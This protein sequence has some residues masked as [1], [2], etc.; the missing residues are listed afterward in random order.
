MIEKGEIA[1]DGK[2]MDLIK[3]SEFLRNVLTKDDIKNKNKLY[4]TSI[5]G[6][7][8]MQEAATVLNEEANGKV[9]SDI[10]RAEKRKLLE[11]HKRAYVGVRKKTLE[12]QRR[13]EGKPLPEKKQRQPLNPPSAVL[14]RGGAEF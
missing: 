12:N 9:L 7:N 11:A 2:P 14:N 6:V 1:A 4:Q 3:T 5:N 13:K 10:E 8:P